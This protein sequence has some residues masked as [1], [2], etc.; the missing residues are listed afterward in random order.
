MTD[1][2][3]LIGFTAVWEIRGVES[4]AELRK[5]TAL[6]VRGGWEGH[7][8]VETTDSFLPFLEKSGYETVIS[9]TLDIY[10]DAGLMARTDL[11]LQCWTMGTITAQQLAALRAAVEGGTGF[12]GWHGGIADAFRSSTDYLH[13]VGGQFACHPR[14]FVDH[15]VEVVP[16][17]ADHPIVAGL[18]RV[19]LHTEQY[20]VLT[21]SRNDV[22]VT[23]TVAALPGDP[24]TEPVVS[25]AVWTRTWGAGR[26]FVCTVGHKQED[27]DVPEIR[28]IIE[29]GLTWASR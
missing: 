11:I 26:I 24:W 6:V 17:R 12:A 9:D 4:I 21:D 23:T 22:L 13:M 5:L 7:C 3:L 28:T 14:N 16:E 18:S 29:R 2:A 27:L 20:W 1:S 19:T 10:L 8:P 25:P 15:T